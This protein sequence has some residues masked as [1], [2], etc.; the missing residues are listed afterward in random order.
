MV[1]ALNEFSSPP[2]NHRLLNGSLQADI[3][4]FAANSHF[5]RVA[6]LEEA[7]QGAILAV[8]YP[9]RQGIRDAPHCFV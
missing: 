8:L 3:R 1:K 4:E 5:V 9:F 7:Q 2:K 6:G